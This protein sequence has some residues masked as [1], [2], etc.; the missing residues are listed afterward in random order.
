MYMH[1]NG[2]YSVPTY[3]AVETVS[4]VRNTQVQ[5]MTDGLVFSLLFFVLFF[6]YYFF[7]KQ[8][9]AND[10]GKTFTINRK[11]LVAC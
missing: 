1:I 2:E 9:H 11:C 5:S 8:E 3:V 7:F 6:Y 10:C 4:D